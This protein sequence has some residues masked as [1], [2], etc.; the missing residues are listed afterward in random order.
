M[1]S[2]RWVVPIRWVLLK[3]TTKRLCHCL[4]LGHGRCWQ[5]RQATRE[6]RDRVKDG[7]SEDRSVGENGAKV[8]GT[9][10]DRS[11]AWPHRDS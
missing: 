2:W 8:E 11:P 6:S 4:V 10:V 7:E 3:K 1:S 5:K 9:S